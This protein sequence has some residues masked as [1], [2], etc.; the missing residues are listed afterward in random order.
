MLRHLFGEAAY[1]PKQEVAD[2]VAARLA[3]KNPR[4]S[5]DAYPDPHFRC[6]LQVLADSYMTLAKSAQ[7]LLSSA[8]LLR[9]LEQ[10]RKK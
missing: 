1:G 9:A 6:R 8:K 3:K 2:A 4:H 10:A 7:V 5:A